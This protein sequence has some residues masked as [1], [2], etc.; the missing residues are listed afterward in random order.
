[1]ISD[2]DLSPPL[3]IPS[4][5]L[6]SYWIRS[7]FSQ[8]TPQVHRHPF[9]C[10]TSSPGISNTFPSSSSAEGFFSSFAFS[11][12]RSSFLALPS[13]H[14]TDLGV[15]P[16]NEPQQA[17]VISRRFSPRSRSTLS[18]SKPPF[19]VSS[20]FPALLD[21][22]SCASRLIFPSLVCRD[23]HPLSAIS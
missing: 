20:L 19:C 15:P 7:S 11:Q 3:F 5:S 12:G 2:H 22:L 1:M 10:R 4:F 21:S 17:V 8:A 6:D 14:E 18:I 13:S 23:G 16:S 9:L